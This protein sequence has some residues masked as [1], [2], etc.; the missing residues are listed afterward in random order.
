MCIMCSAGDRQD[1]VVSSLRAL[2]EGTLSCNVVVDMPTDL[3][4]HSSGGQKRML[5]HWC[6]AGE[7]SLPLPFLCLSSEV[8]REFCLAWLFQSA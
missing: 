3:D 2:L 5:V 8:Q 4:Q 1:A 7:A 6:S